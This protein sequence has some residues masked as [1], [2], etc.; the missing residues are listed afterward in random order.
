[1]SGG[2]VLHCES[3]R[4]DDQVS[5]S[6]HPLAGGGVLGNVVQPPLPARHFELIM[7]NP[8]PK[9]RLVR[10]QHH[11]EYPLT[12]VTERRCQFCPI[13]L[14][15]HCL[16]CH[17]VLSG[18]PADFHRDSRDQRPPCREILEV[19][20]CLVLQ[21]VGKHVA[22]Q[23][24]VKKPQRGMRLHQRFPAVVFP[25][26]KVPLIQIIMRST[27]PSRAGGPADRKTRVRESMAWT[28]AEFPRQQKL[29]AQD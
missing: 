28:T 11:M 21:A 4:V 8:V 17:Q 3:G 7:L 19:S 14:P 18:L 23:L 12:E 6:D 1:M 10:V 2:N 5:F 29:S 9:G 24:R 16:N 26:P 13:L 25:T 15:Q 22:H 27:V 20:E